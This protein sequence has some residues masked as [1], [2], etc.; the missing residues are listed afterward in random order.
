M[1]RRLLRA[2]WRSG[3]RRLRRRNR[4]RVDAG[5]NAYDPRAD[6]HQGGSRTTC[7][8]GGGNCGVVSRVGGRPKRAAPLRVGRGRTASRLTRKALWSGGDALIPHASLDAMKHQTLITA[9]AIDAGLQA[10]GWALSCVLKTEKYYDMFGSA[11]FISIIV[12]CMVSFL[13]G[14]EGGIARKFV[15]SALVLIWALRL[16]GFLVYRVFKTGSDSRFDEVK[17]NPGKFAVYWTMQFLWVFVTLLPVLLVID[18]AKA[19]AFVWSD[20]IGEFYE[21]GVYGALRD[22][23]RGLVQKPNHAH[24]TLDEPREPIRAWLL[25]Q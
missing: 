7:L 22:L 14:G 5:S 15:L 16:G 12:S 8:R 17:A 9:V 18:N 11:T 20:S 24:D 2:A 21:F 10:F 1:V 25:S 13:G 19:V 6:G 23:S 4:R 3:L